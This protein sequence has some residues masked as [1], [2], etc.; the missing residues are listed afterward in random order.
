[1]ASSDIYEIKENPRAKPV[2][3]N[4]FRRHRREKTF[5]EATEEISLN[6]KRRS[7]NSGFR[8]FRHQM[9]KPGYSRRFWLITIGII[10][11]AVLAIFIWDQFFRYP[12]EAERMPGQEKFYHRIPRYD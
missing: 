5:S 2:K 7:K 1:M 3:S 4:R 6:H 11:T 8:R 12:E 9:K 10:T